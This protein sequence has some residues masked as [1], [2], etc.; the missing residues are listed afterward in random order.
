MYSLISYPFPTISDDFFCHQ[1]LAEARRSLQIASPQ[2]N[3][4]DDFIWKQ[5]TAT[6]SRGVK[7][8]RK[9]FASNRGAVDSD[10]EDDTTTRGGNKTPRKRP[11]VS[12]VGSSPKKSMSKLTKLE[13][14]YG[15]FKLSQVLIT[16]LLASTRAVQREKGVCGG[17]SQA[18][19]SFDRSQ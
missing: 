10:P 1:S 16:I 14:R 7:R 2:K 9:S 18:K 15:H 13:V 3:K 17:S 5:V 8:P 6:A 11:R 4:S 12:T 19:L